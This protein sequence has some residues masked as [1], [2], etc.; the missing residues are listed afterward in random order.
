MRGQ[1]FAALFFYTLNHKFYNVT[2]TA[3]PMLFKA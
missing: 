2:Y 3:T 1:L